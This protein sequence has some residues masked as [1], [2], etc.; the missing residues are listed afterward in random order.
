MGLRL[1][2]SGLWKGYGGKD[3]LRGCDYG[4]QGG[5]YSVMG[6]NG[7]GKSTLLRLCALLEPPDR[8]EIGYFDGSQPVPH[9]L[10]LRRSITLVLPRAGIFNTSVLGNVA[11]GQRIRGLGRKESRRR[12]LKALEAVGLDRKA[13]HRALHVSSGEAQRLAIARALVV[14]PKVLFL[15]EPTAS[16]D[17]ENRA[18]IEEII[19]RMKKEGG[20]TVV[21]ATHDRGQAERLSDRILLL[22]DG[23]LSE[24]Q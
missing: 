10:P 20:P 5:V 16:V 7:S 3:V 21:I 23:R 1:S 2:L 15:D 13:G 19:L 8:G 24:A 9:G 14:D 11:Y 12:A 4:F 18:I 22:K 17:E 6:P